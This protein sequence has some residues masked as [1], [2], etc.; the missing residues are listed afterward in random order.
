MQIE[1]TEIAKSEHDNHFFHFVLKHRD[2]KLMDVNG[3]RAKE[4]KDGRRDFYIA[5]WRATQ[6]AIKTLLMVQGLHEELAQKIGFPAGLL[7]YRISTSI[8]PRYDLHKLEANEL[9]SKLSTMPEPTFL[10]IDGEFFTFSLEKIDD[11][12][13]WACFG[14]YFS[15]AASLSAMWRASRPCIGRNIRLDEIE[16]DLKRVDVLHR[17]PPLPPYEQDSYAI[18]SVVRPVALRAKSRKNHKTHG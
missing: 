18:T 15:L 11:N 2:Q 10:R 13:P 5:S 1:A 6:G 4:S 12:E 14:S 8:L 9:D 7:E 16:Q 3:Y 17:F